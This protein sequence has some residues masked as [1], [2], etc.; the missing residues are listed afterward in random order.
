[1]D[2]GMSSIQAYKAPK[3]ER[4]LVSKVHKQ[5]HSAHLPKLPYTSGC[6][7]IVEYANQFKIATN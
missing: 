6:M 4:T 3:Q 2:V 5:G 7:I 1:M